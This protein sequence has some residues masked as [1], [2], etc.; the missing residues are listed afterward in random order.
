MS[1]NRP[2]APQQGQPQQ[3]NQPQ[4]GQQQ[5]S[6]EQVTC[7]V[8]IDVPAE[9]RQ[10]E[11]MRAVNWQA[12]FQSAFEAIKPMLVNL[13]LSLLGGGNPPVGGQGQ[14]GGAPQSRR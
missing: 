9:A 3:Q 2:N 8:T 13:V 14:P 5:Q 4:Q 12:L 7:T 11:G 1:P 6:P 10:H